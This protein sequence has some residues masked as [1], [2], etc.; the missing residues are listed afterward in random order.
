MAEFLILLVLSTGAFVALLHHI[1]LVDHKIDATA[2]KPWDQPAIVHVDRPFPPIRDN[3]SQ[4]LLRLPGQSGK[5]T[6]VDI[7]LGQPDGAWPAD[8]TAQAP[9]LSGAARS[10]RARRL[11]HRTDAAENQA[12]PAMFDPVSADVLARYR[13]FASELATSRG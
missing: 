10:A 6:R 7:G 1:G 9:S 5:D 2:S 12:L 4:I 3:A 8:P 13:K 11:V